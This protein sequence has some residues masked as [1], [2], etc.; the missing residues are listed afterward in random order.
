MQAQFNRE[1]FA[2]AFGLALAAIASSENI[3]KETLKPLSRDV[4]EATHAT[5]DIQYVNQILNVLSP[6]NRKAA[7]VF[8]KHFTGFSY[9]D[10]LRLF[11]K[12]SKKRYEE[13]HANSVAFLQDPHN[14]IW[15]WAER[16]IE[17]EQKPFNVES[18]NTQIKGIITKAQNNGLKMGDVLKAM[19]K[20]GAT[21]EDVLS[22]LD[23]EF[24]VEAK[25]V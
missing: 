9:D 6:V 25:V 14:N 24:Q 10:A 12:K 11:V 3:T 15:T 17:V 18:L 7:V 13:A 21:L 22:I 16:H 5:G 8:F 4:L 1:A 20:A 19:V 23:T 2:L